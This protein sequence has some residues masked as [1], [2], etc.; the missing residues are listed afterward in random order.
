MAEHDRGGSG[1]RDRPAP[2][3]ILRGLGVRAGGRRLLEDVDAEFPA[4]RITLIAG[5]SGSGKSVLLRVIAGLIDLEDRDYEVTG[6]VEIHPAG[7]SGS[8][9]PR[10]GIVFQDFALFDELGA[11]G[12]VLLASDHGGRRSMARR[13]RFAEARR[14]LESLEVPAGIA[15]DRLSGGQKQRLAIA[16]TLAYEPEVIIFDEPSSGLDPAN[17]RRVAERIRRLQEGSGTT[18]IIVTHDYRH[19]APIAH[20]TFILD[21]ATARLRAVEAG[22]IEGA[23][24]DAAAEGGAAGRGSGGLGAP[25]AAALPARAL[26]PIAAVLDASAGASIAL[27]ASLLRLMPLWPSASWGLRY[28]AHYLRLLAS[29]SAIAYFGAAGLIAG[30]VATHFTFKF[31]PF[32]AYTEPLITEELLHGLGFSLYRIVIPVLLTV[33]LAARSGAAIAA[34][35]GGRSFR[36]QLDAMRSLGAPPASYLLT[37]IL[38]AFLLTTPLLLGFGF[39]VARFTSLAVFSYNYPEHAPLFWDGHF[40]RH[41]REPGSMLYLGT[42]WTLAKV[43]A[44]AFG[45]GAIAY[46]VGR[47]AKQSSVE[48]SQGIT[49]TI[50][51]ATLYVLLVHFV[52]A[53]VEF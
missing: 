32:K 11:L 36:R 6:A 45:T 19:L 17:A 9:P 30:F 12:N 26:R 51:A 40:H 44:C 21:P 7:A 46:H 18:T 42:G 35:V 24:I 50:I 13:E 33:L 31:L 20:R 23:T 14:L 1:A 41:L 48:V 22:E 43:L 38:H 28:L 8:A 16:R 4:G 15:V 10:V 25:A 47:R 49:L 34:D 5:P 53:F 2:A 37:N 3:V 27:A 39:L 52:F 29:P